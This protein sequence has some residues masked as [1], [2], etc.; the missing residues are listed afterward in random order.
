MFTVAL[1]R[2]TKGGSDIQELACNA[3]DTRS[4]PGL[5]DSLEKGMATH[6]SLLA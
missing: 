5:D 2:V 4:I 6:S 1:L 3:G